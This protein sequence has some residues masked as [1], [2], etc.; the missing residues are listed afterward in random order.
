MHL[1]PGHRLC[2]Q[3]DKAG[4]LLV[5]NRAGKRYFHLYFIFFLSFLKKIRGVFFKQNKFETVLIVKQVTSA[6][7]H[8]E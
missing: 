8:R 3:H 5:G 6:S 1:S 2:C 4:H 7:L